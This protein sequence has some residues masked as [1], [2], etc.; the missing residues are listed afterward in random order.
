MSKI[1]YLECDLCK[2]Q[3]EV[4][5]KFNRK[6]SKLRLHEWQKESEAGS[7]NNRR[8]AFKN[9]VREIE[10]YLRRRGGK[11]LLKDAIKSIDHHYTTLSSANKCIADMCIRG[12]IKEFSFENG[13]IILK[14]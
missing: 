2:S 14:N 4:K 10:T 12:V 11:V 9:T 8:T 5:P 6:I 7:Q 1:E 3:K 13:F